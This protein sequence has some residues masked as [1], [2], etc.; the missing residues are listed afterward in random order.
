[1]RVPAGSSGSPCRMSLPAR[2]MWAPEAA[3]S[4]MPTSLGQRRRPPVRH[5]CPRPARRH[6]PPAAGWRR[7]GCARQCR[8]PLGRPG[9]WPAATSPT[10]ARRTGVPV[11]AVATSS[12]RT[13]KPSMALL[14]QGGSVSSA[15]RVCGEDAAQGLADGQALRA[16][17]QDVGQDAVARVLEAH[18]LWRGHAASLAVF[19]RCCPRRWCRLHAQGRGAP[20]PPAEPP[21][22]N[23]ERRDEHS[24]GSCCHLPEGEGVELHEVL[25]G[26]VEGPVATREE[27]SGGRA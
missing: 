14:S 8:A 6:P 20:E 1:M 10:T 27:E 25:R 12:L 7:S 19:R 17:R 4:R 5:R 15:R 9:S 3:A 22:G 26:R 16:K 2:R 18:E 24:K 21:G 13:A 23:A 11:E